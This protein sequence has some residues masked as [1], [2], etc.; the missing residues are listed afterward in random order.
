VSQGPV[1]V[2]RRVGPPASSTLRAAT[3]T[4]RAWPLARSSPNRMTCP[5][6]TSVGS[7]TGPWIAKAGAAGALP[8][9]TNR[10]KLGVTVAST[11]AG[12][13]TGAVSP[14]LIEVSPMVSRCSVTL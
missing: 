12:A 6:R 7:E 10:A 5:W 4:T 11:E 14:P 13:R 3:S 9:L 8:A 1:M 2:C